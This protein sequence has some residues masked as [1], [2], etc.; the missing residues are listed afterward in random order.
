MSFR[1]RD[2]IWATRSE[3]KEGA[4]SE[5]LIHVA[6]THKPTGL[7]VEATGKDYSALSSQL[8]EELE[9]L[10]QASSNSEGPLPD[11]REI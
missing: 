1:T 4:H 10:V 8:Q 2:L 3:Q 11:E 6:L 9:E 5:H 7:R